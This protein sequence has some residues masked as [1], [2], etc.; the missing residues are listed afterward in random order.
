M[1]F[2]PKKKALYWLNGNFVLGFLGF[3]NVF[4]AQLEF[5]MSWIMYVKGI[6]TMQGNEPN[7]DAILFLKPLK[8]D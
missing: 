2:Y 5:V 1:K 6:F 3:C 4:A 8:K 7:N